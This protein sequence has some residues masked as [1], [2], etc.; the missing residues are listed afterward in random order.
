[1]KAVCKPHNL[2]HMFQEAANQCLF[3]KISKHCQTG[4]AISV[5][6]SLQM[7]RQKLVPHTGCSL[8]LQGAEHPASVR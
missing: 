8:R 2:Q 6:E 1:M 4:T 5:T 7:R 3:D